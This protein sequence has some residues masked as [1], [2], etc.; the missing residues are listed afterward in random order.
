M[1]QDPPTFTSASDLRQSSVAR[2]F[3]NLGTERGGGGGGDGNYSEL[4][5]TALPPGT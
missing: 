4:R 1:P 5:F 2:N 3:P